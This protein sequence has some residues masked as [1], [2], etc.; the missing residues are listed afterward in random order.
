MS[1][2]RGWLVVLI[3]FLALGLAFSARYTIGLLIPVWEA[4]FGWTRGF[5]SSGGAL[6]LLVMAVVAPPIGNMID[7]LS[8]GVVFGG[9]LI[10]IGVALAGTAG[11]TAG[12]QFVLVYCVIGGIGYGAIGLPL[13]STTIARHFVE[14]RGFATSVGTSGVGAGQLFLLPVFAALLG[15][16][17]WRGSLVVYGIA[18]IAF[19]LLVMFILRDQRS[20]AD[21]KAARAREKTELMTARLA[22]ILSNRTFWLVGLA[23]LICGFTTAGIVKVHLLPYA[24][25]CGFPPVQSAAAFGVLAAFDAVGMLLAGYLTDRMNRPLLL[26]S[27]YFLRALT[28]V[29]L[30]FISADVSLLFLFAILFGTLD[31][32]TVPPMASIIASHVGL[33]VMGLTMGILFALHSIGAAT[34]AWMGGFMFDLFARYDW[35]WIAGFG[36]CLIAA[37]LVWMVPEKSRNE[38]QAV[39]AAA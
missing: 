39:P 2:P 3:T 22:L 17:G 29:L 10:V 25:A 15:A 31:F 18:I 36:V 26:G 1:N 35:V 8:P 33:R 6:M 37:V 14:N 30:M 28:F 16:V 20:M 9:G 13:A 19:G 11:M 32:A 7:R 23:Y 4:D 27:V 21:R 34:G 5:I 38:P 24:A 12:W